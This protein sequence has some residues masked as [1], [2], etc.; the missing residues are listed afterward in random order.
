MN[1]QYE[2]CSSTQGLGSY[3]NIGGVNQLIY[4][5]GQGYGK[6][7]AQGLQTT[8]RSFR[9]LAIMDSHLE[10]QILVWKCR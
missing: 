10:L 2:K 8:W 7:Q 3:K 1:Q 9:N 5:D 4:T 6:Q